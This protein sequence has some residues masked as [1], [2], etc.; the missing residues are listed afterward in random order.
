[1]EQRTLMPSY[2]EQF[3]DQ[4]LGDIVAFLTATGGRP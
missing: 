3:S 1:M 4:E 2:A